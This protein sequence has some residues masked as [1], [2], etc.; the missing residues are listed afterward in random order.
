MSTFLSSVIFFSPFLSTFLRLSVQWNIYEKA[1]ILKSIL[2]LPVTFL[3]KSALSKSLTELSVR[4]RPRSQSA[5]SRSLTELS[6]ISQSSL[7][8]LSVRVRLS[9]LLWL[10]LCASLTAALRTKHGQ[11]DS[12]TEWQTVYWSPCLLVYP[13]TVSVLRRDEG[14]K[15]PKVQKA[16]GYIWPCILIHTMEGNC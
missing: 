6:V 8:E 13:S 2:W 4:V 3:A 9:S 10:W 1:F 5:L 12:I 14:Y 11:T 16:K 15:V 7:S